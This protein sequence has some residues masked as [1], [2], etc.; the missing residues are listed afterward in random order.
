MRHYEVVFLVHPDQSEQVGA[1]I[2]R[3]KKVIEDNK[4]TVHRIEDW[5]RR[6][7][8][9]TIN[10]VHKAHYVLMNIEVDQETL[11][12]IE[13]LF[14]FNDAII[15]NLVLKKNEA[16]T[17]QSAMMKEVEEE[18]RKE[19][20]RDAARAAEANASEAKDKAAESTDSEAKADEE[21]K[22]ESSA[23]ADAETKSTETAEET[24]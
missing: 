21:A 5:G 13:N 1:M 19:E 4:G 2:E 24:A 23:P 14:R 9:Y 7:L 6:R 18:R 10:K 16:V 15:R 22:E 11:G 17:E 8:A 3:Y 12:E 20:E